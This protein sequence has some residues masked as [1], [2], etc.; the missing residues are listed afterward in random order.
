MAPLI[1]I[2]LTIAQQFAPHLLRFFGAG[3]SSVAAAEKIVG[4]AQ[5]ATGAQTPEEALQRLQIDAQ[6]QHEFRMKALEREA[7]I[8]KAYLADI[9]NARSREVQIATAESAPTLNKVIA[10]VLAIIVVIGGG[11]VLVWSPDADVRLGVTS[12][13]T[14]VLGYYFGTSMGSTKANQMLRDIARKE[15]Q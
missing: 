4:L 2:A 13:I 15:V 10:P 8:E 3:D 1:P 11:A 7:E 12:L 9:Q 6:A 5:Q 14:M